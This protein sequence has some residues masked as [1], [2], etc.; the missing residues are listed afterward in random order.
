MSLGKR[1]LIRAVGRAVPDTQTSDLS[2]EELEIE[3]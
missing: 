3:K 2:E 1:A